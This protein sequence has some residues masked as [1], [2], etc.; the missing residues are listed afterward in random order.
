M[1]FLVILKHVTV[2]LKDLL[3]GTTQ[4]RGEEEKSILLATTRRSR[5]KSSVKHSSNT[6]LYH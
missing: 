4:E 5:L 3:S 2:R 1:V 6:D